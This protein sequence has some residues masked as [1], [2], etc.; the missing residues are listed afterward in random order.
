MARLCGVSSSAC[1][2]DGNSAS[3]MGFEG[4]NTVPGRGWYHGSLHT[5]GLQAHLRWGGSPGLTSVGC[6]SR[7]PLGRALNAKLWPRVERCSLAGSVVSA[8]HS[9]SEGM[10]GI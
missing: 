8:R 7:Y 9:R 6:S 5:G 4:Y 2:G 10:R 1:V 3:L